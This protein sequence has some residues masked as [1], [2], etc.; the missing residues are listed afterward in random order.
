MG[1]EYPVC[2]HFLFDLNRVPDIKLLGTTSDINNKD[3]KTYVF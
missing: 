1:F 2:F 3:F